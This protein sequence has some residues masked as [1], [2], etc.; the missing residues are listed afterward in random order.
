MRTSKRSS[1]KQKETAR[2]TVTITSGEMFMLFLS[3]SKEIPVIEAIDPM[4]LTT[5]NVVVLLSFNF[6]QC[7]RSTQAKISLAFIR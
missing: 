6:D 7:H 4:K 5:S 1:P 3:Q 2:R